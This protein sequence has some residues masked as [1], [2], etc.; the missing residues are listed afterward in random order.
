ME[1]AVETQAIGY[2]TDIFVTEPMKRNR[3]EG[4]SGSAIETL[5][6]VMICFSR[7]LS[8]VAELS[9]VLWQMVLH[10][11]LSMKGVVGVL[12]TFVLFA[13]WAGKSFRLSVDEVEII[14]RK[15]SCLHFL[16]HRVGCR[17]YDCCRSSFIHFPY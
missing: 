15:S 13:F 2:A 16:L 6:L 8:V 5:K 7:I 11:A 10:L 1:E 9:E 3:N 14:L 17:R 4:R 12:A